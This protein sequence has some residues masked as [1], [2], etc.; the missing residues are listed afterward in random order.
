MFSADA[1]EFPAPFCAII[2]S[3][4][5]ILLELLPMVKDEVDLILRVDQDVTY[6]VVANE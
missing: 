2:I 5:S 4:F 3:S 1:A 6:V